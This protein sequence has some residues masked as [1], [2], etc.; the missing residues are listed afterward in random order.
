MS[1]ELKFNQVGT[2]AC[3][4]EKYTFFYYVA[5]GIQEITLFYNL[6]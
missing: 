5:K 6:N 2:L 3:L 4:H 1:S